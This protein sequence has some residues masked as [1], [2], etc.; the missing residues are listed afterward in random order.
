MG[1]FICDVIRG[2]FFDVNV[3]HFVYVDPERFRNNARHVFRMIVIQ[4][5]FSFVNSAA[6]A[7]ELHVVVIRI[8]V[9]PFFAR[10]DLRNELAMVRFDVVELGGAQGFFVVSFRIAR[11]R[12]EPFGIPR[13]GIR[14][15]ATGSRPVRIRHELV[16]RRPNDSIGPDS[17]RNVPQVEGDVFRNA[18]RYR[19]FREGKRNDGREFHSRAGNGEFVAGSRYREFRYLPENGFRG[20]AA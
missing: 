7:F 12:L 6:E 5:E 11:E 13:D 3:P 15:F 19:S 8:R 14:A 4:R 10:F 2:Q 20:F 17:F 16:E 1:V 9:S 18:N